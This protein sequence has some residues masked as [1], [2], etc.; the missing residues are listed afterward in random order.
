MKNTNKNTQRYHS[1]ITVQVSICVISSKAQKLFTGTKL[2]S[3]RRKTRAA[4]RTG[5][6]HNKKPPVP[7]VTKTPPNRQRLCVDDMLDLYS[8]IINVV[9]VTTQQPPVAP[10]AA[11]KPAPGATSDYKAVTLT[12]WCSIHKSDI[13]Y[14]KAVQI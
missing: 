9:I 5:D 6:F 11:S 8:L 10:R 2:Q 3:S 7:P 13:S 4:G 12:D 14:N 1:G